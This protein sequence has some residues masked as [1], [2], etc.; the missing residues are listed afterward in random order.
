MVAAVV[1]D[2]SLESKVSPTTF[3]YIDG[4]VD[5]REVMDGVYRATS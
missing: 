2:S 4:R 5:M 3:T 1:E